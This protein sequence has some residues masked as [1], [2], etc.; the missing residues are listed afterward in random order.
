MVT[1]RRRVPV[2]RLSQA[3]GFALAALLVLAASGA[4]AQ[5]P[6]QYPGQYPP[7]QYPPG[8]Y[9]PG[10]Y[11]P[12]QY[13]PGQYPGNTG[14]GGLPIPKI[15]WPKRLGRK[16]AKAAV[17]Q[18]RAGGW[19]SPRTGPKG[20]LLE[21]KNGDVLRFRLLGKTEFTDKSGKPMRDSLLN[22]GDQLSVLVDAEDEETAIRV[23][24]NRAGK[25]QERAN[26]SK[27]V[28]MARVR[29][30]SASDTGKARTV[31][32]H[33]PGPE[34]ATGDAAED[35]APAG[36]RGENSRGD[37][38]EALT[39]EEARTLPAED[40]EILTQVK[41]AAAMFTASLPDYVADQKTTR[42]AQINGDWRQLDVVTAEIAYASGEEELRNIRVDGQPVARPPD[43]GAWGTGE[44]GTTLEQVLSVAASARFDRKPDSRLKGHSV[45]VFGYEVDQPH[46]QWTLVA[47]DGRKHNAA[48]GGAIYVDPAS[49]R[50]LRIE[51]ET[52]SIPAN[53]PISDVEIVLDYGSAAI[54]GKQH[55]LPSSTETKACANGGAC[56]RNVTEFRNYRKFTASSTLK[57]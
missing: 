26:A 7:G 42:F 13:P 25:D 9:P 39:P 14:P 5:T 34:A 33:E 3:Q 1:R 31:T 30:P 12:G 2:R 28:D 52:R 35:S 17:D 8:Q 20:L 21:V 55:F 47:P 44:F 48:Y 22:P 32:L 40:T 27:P 15:G 23:V 51:Q 45:V 54:E 46:S 11:P 57:F 24:F 16:T 4:P 38:S 19:R 37:N 43:S 6:R 50:I 36:A 49:R 18:A 56:T 53:F 29:A 10:Q 41:E